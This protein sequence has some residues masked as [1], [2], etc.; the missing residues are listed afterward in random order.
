[1]LCRLTW[2]CSARRDIHPNNAGQ[3][4]IAERILSVTGYR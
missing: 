3:M 2:V 4:A 1:M